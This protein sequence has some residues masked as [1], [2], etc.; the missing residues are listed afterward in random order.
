MRDLVSV[1]VITFVYFG[2]FTAA[3]VVGVGVGIGV[4]TCIGRPIIDCMH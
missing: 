2:V 1:Y 4:T 3:A